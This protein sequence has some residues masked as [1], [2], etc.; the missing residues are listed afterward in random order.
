MNVRHDIAHTIVRLLIFLILFTTSVHAVDPVYS[1]YLSK[2]EAQHRIQNHINNLH[3]SPLT[4][5]GWSCS[6]T[7]MPKLVKTLRVDHNGY[8]FWKAFLDNGIFCLFRENQRILKP[9][10]IGHTSAGKTKYGTVELAEALCID[11]IIQSNI[12]TSQVGICIGSNQ[13]AVLAEK[14][15][16]T[17]NVSIGPLLT[18][19]WHQGSPFNDQCPLYPGSS[20]QHASV[21]CVPIAG[22]Q[23]LKY[24]QWPPYGV[25]QHAYFDVY[26]KINCNG[27]SDLA[28]YLDWD[29]MPLKTSL[30]TTLEQ[31]NTVA[32]F[33]YTLAV[34]CNT[35]F[36]LNG[37]G[38]DE[39]TLIEALCEHYYYEKGI[40]I[41]PGNDIACFISEIKDDLEASRPVLAHITG[42]SFIIDGYASED[43]AEYLHINYGWGE[44]ENTAWFAPN[45]IPGGTIWWVYTGIKPLFVPLFTNPGRVTNENATLSIQWTLPTAF[46]S[47][48]NKI[49]L[50]QRTWIS[51][52]YPDAW[53]TSLDWILEGWK[54]MSSTNYA[55]RFM[56]QASSLEG[57]NYTLTIAL[58]IR[59]TPQS[60]ISF[61]YN[62]RLGSNEYFYVETALKHDGP[63]TPM[64]V[65]NNYSSPF[66]PYWENTKVNFAVTN[67]TPMY[68]RFRANFDIPN[69]RNGAVD[70]YDILLDQVEV[71]SGFKRVVE[72][73]ASNLSP[74][75]ISN[76]YTGT[77]YFSLQAHDG[78]DWKSL[79]PLLAVENKNVAPWT[80]ADGDGIAD[81][82]E[83]AVFG[84]MSVAGF[85]TDFDHDGALDRAEWLCGT[86]PKDSASCL[87][88]SACSAGDRSL[89]LSW[90]S[91]SDIRYRLEYSTNLIGWIPLFE[92]VV[93]AQPPT[94]HCSIIM[95]TNAICCFY[96]VRP[97]N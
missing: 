19:Y 27:R 92:N 35:D 48:T 28:Q 67:I 90:T 76:L 9:C 82:W 88:L 70:V 2:I 7:G 71:L 32:R 96:R 40:N 33:I 1:N 50:V 73:S 51:G 53:T 38:S 52:R 39:G 66:A 62:A 24:Y 20:S 93:D 17:S 95:P 41:M 23:I 34:A 43:G 5:K 30:Y 78:A 31:S 61:K 83:L 3:D 79:S 26:G 12:S 89:D 18:S 29:S 21:G 4:E 64:F 86:N 72:Q 74:F 58:P 63:W 36:E 11:G 14:E 77:Y 15:L 60:A 49:S 57:T 59:I 45:A 94:N 87:R 16:K 25:G 46:Q 68:F 8:V 56:C 75:L 91:V 97:E 44:Q 13:T 54:N 84:N 37:S 80:D 47:A 81:E 65:L 10:W 42:H 6:T 22:A 69:V 85:E 55:N